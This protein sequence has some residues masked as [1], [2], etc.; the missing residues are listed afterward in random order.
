MV[1]T[2]TEINMVY[3]TLTIAPSVEML[4]KDYH[5]QD[6]HATCGAIT[7]ARNVG[8]SGDTH[9]DISLGGG[10]RHTHYVEDVG[11]VGSNPTGRTNALGV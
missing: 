7:N 3:D 4:P 10:T 1:G 8:T 11:S 5:G 6:S 2:G 9:I